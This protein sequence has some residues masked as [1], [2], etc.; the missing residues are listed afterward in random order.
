[1]TAPPGLAS[2]PGLDAQDQLVLAAVTHEKV[3]HTGQGLWHHKGM[4]LPAYVQHIANDLIQERGMTMSRAIATAISRCKVW[5]AGGD[6][7]NPDTRAKAC[8]AV[9]E[10]EKLKGQARAAAGNGLAT[11]EGV[12]LVAAGTWSLSSGPT[13]FTTEDLKRAIDA[14]T[15]PAVG[16][17]IIK[18]GHVDPRFDGQPAIG[19]VLNMRLDAGE[20]ILRGD[21]TG[22]PAWL[23]DVM[24]S[25]FPR[26]SI[27][28]AF[29]FRCQTG[30]SH[31]FVITGLALLGVTPPGVGALNGLDDVRALYE[32]RADAQVGRTWRTLAPLPMGR[33]RL[34][35]L[36]RHGAY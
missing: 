21:L 9:A 12:D 2:P 18:L 36:A 11:L 22:L 15:C 16:P 26:R 35:R 24:A 27:E 31:P 28:G 25:A 5:C 32:A 33:A 29:D 10:W 4:Q 14:A 8:A 6:N 23:G 20:T 1:M 30:H 19:R 17:P 34:H 3:G 13:E 7:V